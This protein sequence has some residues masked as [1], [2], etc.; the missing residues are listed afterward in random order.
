MTINV[1][2]KGIGRSMCNRVFG[3]HWCV[4]RRTDAAERSEIHSRV[5]RGLGGVAPIQI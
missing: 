4:P 1:R 5:A 2:K 3:T